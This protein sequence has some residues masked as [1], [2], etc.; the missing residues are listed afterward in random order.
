MTDSTDSTNHCE[1]LRI[2][3]ARRLIRDSCLLGT[4]RS[5]TSRA[6]IRGEVEG[7]GGDE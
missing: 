5:I 1:S 7:G 2:T 4:N 3:H 6:L